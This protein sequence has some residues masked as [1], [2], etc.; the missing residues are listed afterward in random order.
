MIHREAI[1]FASE[2]S[3]ITKKVNGKEIIIWE[4]ELVN[5][6]HLGI[7]PDRVQ[8]DDDYIEVE[9]R[10]SERLQ[11]AGFDKNYEPT[12]EGKMCESIL[13]LLG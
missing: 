6:K 1:I 8:S 7:D 4:E 2:P 13:D 5:L 9:D 11:I 10:V 3:D 12:E